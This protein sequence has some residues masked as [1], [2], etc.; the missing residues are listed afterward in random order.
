MSTATSKVVFLIDEQSLMT[1][2]L[3][4]QQLKLSIMR[5]LI[6]HHLQKRQI[7]W[8]FRFF[9]TQ[10]RYPSESMRRFYPL[11][12]DSFEA[13]EKEY[14]KRDKHRPKQV[15]LGTPI[16]RIKQV[17]KEVIGDF[18][19]ENNDLG[20]APEATQNHIFIMSA[21]PSSL[22]EMNQFFVSPHPDDSKPLNIAL[23]PQYFEQ[24]KS[25]LS[26]TLLQSYA[27]RNILLNIIDTYKKSPVTRPHDQWIERVTREGFGSCLH[28]FR[29]QY[30]PIELLV[31]DTC[32][33]GRSFL[34]DLHSLLAVPGSITTTPVW[35]G[36]L[37]MPK[38]SLDGMVLYPSVH[39]IVP[40]DRVSRLMFVSEMR[41]LQTCHVSQFSPDWLLSESP[42]GSY[43]LTH[44]MEDPSCA[45]KD[46]LSE[47]FH[48]QSV[49]IAELIPLEGFEDHVQDQKVCIE[50]YS[51]GAAFVRY[52]DKDLLNISSNT[53]VNT[54]DYPL[55]SHRLTGVTL[56]LTLPTERL[57]EENVSY[58][59][60]KLPDIIKQTIV[61][62][63]AAKLKKQRL[64]I[65]VQK[66]IKPQ[67]AGGKKKAMFPS[68]I[69]MLEKALEELYFESI[70]TQKYTIENMI[71]TVKRW[72]NN[73]SRNHTI[74]EIIDTLFKYTSTLEDLEAKYK[75][76][77]SQPTENESTKML[78]QSFQQA[79]W[80]QVKTRFQSNARSEK[81][82]CLTV[83]TREAQIQVILYCFICRLMLKLPN[84][85][86]ERDPIS[87]AEDFFQKVVVTLTMHDL[88]RFL[89]ELDSEEGPQAVKR[90]DPCDLS[91]HAFMTLLEKR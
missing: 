34:S 40:S 47:L 35:R 10:T 61:V 3:S 11:T 18:Q 90:R 45:Y 2:L 67:A 22:I 51:Q 32:L 7:E 14:S 58:K 43:V 59:I 74:Q 37:N 31:R 63:S 81:L 78:E 8:G 55:G 89:S 87:S 71:H 79:W 73:L 41:V 15:V 21:C 53:S 68:D 20:S 83:K 56:P 13:L 60:K 33:Y 12:L 54:A 46:Y 4:L 75:N 82:M 66:E 1:S 77:V 42:L 80:Q 76:G 57:T 86:L 50:P 64:S 27:S 38:A 23:L 44:D 16:M 6:Y 48:T 30:I 84:S 88:G 19:W 65:S 25:D 24:T 36:T 91:D 49:M 26:S 17:L 39:E 52:I 28:Q 5:I 69:D 72:L 70:Y 85:Q 62:P 9:S 29:G